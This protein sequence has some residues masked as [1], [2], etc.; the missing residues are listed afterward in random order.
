MDKELMRRRIEAY[1]IQCD[2]SENNSDDR[3]IVHGGALMIPTRRLRELLE[4]ARIGLE[5]AE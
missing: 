3:W 2:V 4:L 5:H 1:E